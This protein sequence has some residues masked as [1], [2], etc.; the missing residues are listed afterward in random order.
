MA[1]TMQA[2]F[3]AGERKLEVREIE[4]PRPAAGEVL[5]EVKACGL[6]GSDLHQF[7]GKWDQPQYVPGHEIAGEVIEVG[8]GVCQW[9]PGDRVCV[10]PFLYCGHCCFCMAGRYFHCGEMG[11]LTLTAHGGFAEKVVAPSYA[12]YRLPE[13]L[14]FEVGA[15]A[16]PLA[17][18]V[19]AV[20]LAQVDYADDVLVLGAGTIGLMAMSAANS[21]GAHLV[22][23]SARHHYQRQAAYKLG[24]DQVLD[25]DEQQLAEQVSAMF[26][27]GP[28]VVLETVGSAAGTFQRA[29]D[30]AGR[31][32][33]V[34]FVGGNV[35]AVDRFDFE[36]ISRKELTVYGSGAYAQLGVRRDYEV[37]L[38]LLM[39]KPTIY[40]QLVTHRF[41]LNEIQYAFDMAINKH[42]S[43]AIKVMMVR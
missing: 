16:E 15:L 35:G 36:P 38:D 40:A 43:Q 27:R 17:V 26:E 14:S 23:I 37:T 42:E 30:L 8:E 11:F 5:I 34:V 7:D 13:A 18:G 9:Q 6:C 12:L 3:F 25:T 10:E 33:R 22:A 19:H 2:A 21:F 39:Q 29:V 1:E 41:N 28:S 4:M 32:G 20:R 24:A 31:L